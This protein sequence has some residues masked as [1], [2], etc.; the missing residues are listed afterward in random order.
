LIIRLATK[1][2]KETF[3]EFQK[4]F[5][6][7]YFLKEFCSNFTKIPHSSNF[8][9]ECPATTTSAATVQFSI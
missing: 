9:L 1:I 4:I 3:A 2:L 8:L 6:V 5:V 7:I